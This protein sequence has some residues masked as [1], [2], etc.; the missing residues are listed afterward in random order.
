MAVPYSVAI[1]AE[2]DAV[3]RNTLQTKYAVPVIVNKLSDLH[4]HYT[5]CKLPDLDGYYG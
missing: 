5:T 2:T 1:A 3:A 4:R